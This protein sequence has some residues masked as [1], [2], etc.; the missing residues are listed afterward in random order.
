MLASLIF[1]RG[2]ATHWL[3]ADIDA[4]IQP[5]PLL[6]AGRAAGRDL[7]KFL[8]ALKGMVLVN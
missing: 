2:I 4:L 3:R 8:F 5:W 7:N 1:C 6:R